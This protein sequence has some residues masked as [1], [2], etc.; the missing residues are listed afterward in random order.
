V[1]V[2]GQR[3]RVYVNRALKLDYQDPDRTRSSGRVALAAYTG[4]AGECVVWFDNL[5]VTRLGERT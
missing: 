3:Y 5:K 1:E 4:G 2:Q